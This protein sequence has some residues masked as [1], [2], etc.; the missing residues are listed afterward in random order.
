[1]ERTDQTAGA[2]ELLILGRCRLECIRHVRGAVGLVGQAAS[3]ARV[4]LPRRA[5][6]WTK[7]QRRQR[8]DLLGVGHRRDW[9][10]DALRLVDAGAVVG[11]NALQ[12]RLDDAARG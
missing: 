5:S 9:T 6:R 8:V 3:L 2:S 12:I 11:L 7:G 4:E 10:E 1:M